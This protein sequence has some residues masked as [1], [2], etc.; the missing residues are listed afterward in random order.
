MSLVGWKDKQVLVPEVSIRIKPSVGGGSV[1]GQ[2]FCFINKRKI[3][4][5]S[6]V[7]W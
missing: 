5:I 2:G 1:E 3:N 7:E 6:T 4:F